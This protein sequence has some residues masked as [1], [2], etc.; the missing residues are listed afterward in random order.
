MAEEKRSRCCGALLIGGVQCEAC[1]ADDRTFVPFCP[2]CHT[3]KEDPLDIEQ[4]EETG[5]CL[6]CDKLRGEFAGDK[7]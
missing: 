7:L 6:A 2:S 5:E 1:G 3:Y 4:I